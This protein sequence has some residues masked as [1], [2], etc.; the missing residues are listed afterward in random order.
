MTSI[1]Y[2]FAEDPILDG[3]NVHE[4][5]VSG[6]SGNYSGQ[7]VNSRLAL[8]MDLTQSAEKVCLIHEDANLSNFQ[9]NVLSLVENE[10]KV[11][12][13]D[14]DTRKLDLVKSKLPQD[15]FIVHT[16]FEANEEEEVCEW[17]SGKSGKKFLIAD[18]DTVA[19]YE[20]DTVII[21]VSEYSKDTISSVC[22]RATARLIVCSYE[23]DPEKPTRRKNKL[24]SCCSVS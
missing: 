2:V 5:A 11:L 20:F 23:R 15:S 18:Q 24:K 8:P 14:Y 13:I 6:S 7:S 22:Q 9:R 12:I 10:H 1:L 3:Q 21:V 19:G 4:I 17:I 16:R